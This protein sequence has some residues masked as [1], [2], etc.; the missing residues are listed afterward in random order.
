MQP[1]AGAHLSASRR[2]RNQLKPSGSVLTRFFFGPATTQTPTARNPAKVA[3]P[4]GNAVSL[5]LPIWERHKKPRLRRS[6]GPA[7]DSRKSGSIYARTNDYRLFARL[8]SKF[9]RPVALT[10]ITLAI[11]YLICNSKHSH[12]NAAGRLSLAKIAP[13]MEQHLSVTPSCSTISPRRNSPRSRRTEGAVCS[14][15]EYLLSQTM[16]FR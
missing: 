9:C 1:N 13:K 16:A 15:S 6:L 12:T 7:F 2:V 4:S 3:K 5:P 14:E 11:H 8:S 10:L